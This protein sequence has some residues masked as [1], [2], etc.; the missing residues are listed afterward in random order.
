MTILRDNVKSENV[1]KKKEKKRNKHRKQSTSDARV[2]FMLCVYVCMCACK[3]NERQPN[4]PALQVSTS[5]HDHHEIPKQSHHALGPDSDPENP[6]RHEIFAGREL[7]WL[8]LTSLYP[9]C[10]AA[11]PVLIRDS[12]RGRGRGEHNLAE[13]GS[14]ER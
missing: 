9:R 13:H 11:K 10:Q 8:R 7:I 6:V 14:G 12:G 5:P 3:R 1:T 2:L 4:L